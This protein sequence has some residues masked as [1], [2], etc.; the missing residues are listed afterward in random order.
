MAEQGGQ[1]Q[2]DEYIKCSACKCK[3]INDYDHIK[4]DFGYTRLEERYK[5]CIRCRGL[6]KVY[7]DSHHESLRPKRETYNVIN[8]V[9]I[10]AHNFEKIECKSCGDKVC[11]NALRRHEREK[12]CNRSS[13]SASSDSV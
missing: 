11:R 10:N 3:Y 6:K 2:R 8:R 9:R 7:Y 12:C 1:Q 13:G 4:I 5:C